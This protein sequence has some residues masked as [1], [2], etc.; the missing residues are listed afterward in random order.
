MWPSPLEYWCSRS[1]RCRDLT[2]GCECLSLGYEAYVQA[3][4][5]ADFRLISNL[6]DEGGNNTYLVHRAS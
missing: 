4:E 1:K 3:L 6:L 5:N 2:T